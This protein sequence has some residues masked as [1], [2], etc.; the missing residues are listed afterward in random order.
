MR[1]KLKLTE[2][3]AD[4]G[5]QLSTRLHANFLPKLRKNYKN[6]AFRGRPTATVL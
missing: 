5:F 1:L 3:N 4:N 2:I 6:I